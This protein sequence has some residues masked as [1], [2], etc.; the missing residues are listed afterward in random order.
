MRKRIAIAGTGTRAL[1]FADGIIKH[2]GGTSELVALHDLNPKRMEGFQELIGRSVPAFTDFDAMIAEARPDTIVICA[3]DKAHPELVERAFAN[4]LE[5]VSEKPL[6]I[7]VEGLRRIREAERKYGK[8]VGVTFNMRFAPYSAKIK[9]VLQES[10]IGKITTVSAEWFID[11]T[12]GI[13]Y[14]HRWHS[15]MENG[16]GLLVHKATHNFDLLNWFLDDVPEEVSA[17]GS[18]RVF[19]RNNS[20]NGKNCRTCEHNKRCWAAMK[21]SLEDADLNPGGEAD[22]F[23]KI[24]FQ[25]EGE[26]GYLRDRCCFAPD[27]DIYDT[28]NAL[29]KYR[30]G[31]QVSYALNA[32][33]PWQGYKIIFTGLEGRLEV[34]TVNPSTRPADFRD[35]DVI[36]VIRGNTRSDITM[37]ETVLETDNSSHGGGDARMIAKLFGSDI[38]SPDPLEQLAGFEDGASSAL[39]GIMA[40]ESIASGAP[41]RI[42]SIES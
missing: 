32:Y 37:E 29:I 19:G 3:T 38:D 4:G 13:E 16:G 18:L 9:E 21:S 42:P 26:D 41:K 17:Y 10:P 6:A 5:A 22:L 27:I 11:K 30:S 28:M 14:F 2:C 1:N 36:R 25:A 23:N 31:T 12:H 35:A 40:N 8:K 24:Y 7:S 20:F 34:G 33:S 15:K 39:V